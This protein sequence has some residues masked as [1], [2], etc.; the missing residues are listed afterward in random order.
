MC[1]VAIGTETDGSIV[2]PSATCGIVGIK[3]TV[4]LVSRFG[5]IPISHTQDTAGPMARTVRD[6]AILLGAITGADPRDGATTDSRG[7]SYTDYSTFLDAGGLK[8]AR[9]GVVRMFAGFD[10]EVDKLLDNVIQVLKSGGAEVIDPVDIPSLGPASGLELD[11]LMYEFKTDLNAYLAS[12][13]PNVHVKT[14]K[15]V[16]DF[17]EKNADREMP[18]FGQDIFIRAEEKGPLT[19]PDYLRALDQTRALSRVQGIDAV[20]AKGRLDALIAPT[21]GPAWTT[22]LVNGDHLSGASASGAAIAG[23][24]NITVPCGLVHGLPIG[25]SFFGKAWSEPV[26]L[27]IAYAYEQADKHRTAPRFLPTLDLG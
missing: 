3:P 4:G 16:I 25:V 14:L 12:L 24:P 18:Y 1:V 2:C 6:A 22:D 7:K 21:G 17:N 23:Y 11:V 9:I 27:R 19:T 20:M 13:G 15:D 5:V 10:P 26:L 8:A